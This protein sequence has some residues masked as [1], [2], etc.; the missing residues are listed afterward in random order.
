MSVLSWRASPPPWC[1]EGRAALPLAA[2]KRRSL[3]RRDGFL[4]A[5]TLVHGGPVQHD[6]GVRDVRGEWRAVGG[7][8]LGQAGRAG[9]RHCRM[10]QQG[11]L[12]PP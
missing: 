7:G 1:Y 8:G 3:D 6:G 12:G 10:R 9:A 2:Y 5:R 4:G 11:A